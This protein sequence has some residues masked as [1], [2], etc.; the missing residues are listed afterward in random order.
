[1]ETETSRDESIRHF[2]E[3]LKNVDRS[4]YPKIMQKIQEEIDKGNVYKTPPDSP[5]K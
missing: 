3:L 4:L 1:M 5:E 2:L